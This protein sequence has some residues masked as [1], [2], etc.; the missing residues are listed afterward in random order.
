MGTVAALESF[1]DQY[2]ISMELCRVDGS[3][4]PQEGEIDRYLCRLSKH[5]EQV[6]VYVAVPSEEES[7]TL[8]DVLFMLVL[9]ASGCEML[10]DYYGRRE[11]LEYI[12]G[13]D[14]NLEEF[15]EFW[16][17]YRSRCRQTQKVRTFLGEELYRE[18]IVQF[19]FKD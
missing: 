17:E 11:H 19:G 9:D 2:D 12:F 15:D 14:G 16:R 18:L 3:A 1:I 8:S 4:D 6:S 7:L 10:K 13:S 5:G